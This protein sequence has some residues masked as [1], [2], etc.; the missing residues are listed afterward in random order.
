[1]NTQD[2]PSSESKDQSHLDALNLRLSNERL[3]LKEAATKA[4]REIRTVWIAQLEKEI[5]GELAFL[6]MSAPT[7]LDIDDDALFAELNA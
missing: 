4:E 2:T 6:G 5:D 3:R 1:M 7:P